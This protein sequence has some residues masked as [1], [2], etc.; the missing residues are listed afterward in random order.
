MITRR[1]F[2]NLGAHRS[3]RASDNQNA[4]AG[5]SA[6]PSPSPHWV[7]PPG[8][9]RR[10]WTRPQH[11]FAAIEMRGLMGEMDLPKSPQF[12]GAKLKESMKDLEAL[13]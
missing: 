4:Q 13:G 11:G 9:G 3:C 1:E 2:V 7:A 5:R 12:T 8:N 6:C 10:F